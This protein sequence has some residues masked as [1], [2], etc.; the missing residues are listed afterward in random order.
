MTDVDT[1]GDGV[2]DA[3]DN[4]QFGPAIHPKQILMVT[5]WGRPA[6]HSL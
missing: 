1:D 2:L 6:T 4:L 3:V 5:V